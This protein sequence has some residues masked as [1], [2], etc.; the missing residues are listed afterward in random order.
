MPLIRDGRFVADDWVRPD[1]ERGDPAGDGIAAKLLLPLA[2][3]TEQGS[4]LAGKTLG[5]E[6]GNDVDPDALT[7]WFGHLALISVLFP[8]SAD[9]RGYSIATRL[10][11]LGFTGELRASGHLIADQYGL[12]RSCGFDTVE[13]SD[14]QAERQPEAHWIEAEHAMSLAYQR[15]YGR[16][17]NILSARWA[18]G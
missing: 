8:K 5:V 11:R 2:V 18:A 10:R 13:I 16:F 17:Q 12:A 9:G 7:S 3:L 14:A 6:I 4:A 15:G 1:P